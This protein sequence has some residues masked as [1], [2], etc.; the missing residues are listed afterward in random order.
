MSA[1]F[2]IKH[3]YLSAEKPSCIKNKVHYLFYA[4]ILKLHF[5]VVWVYAT[6]INEIIGHHCYGLLR[7]SSS[8]FFSVPLFC[9]VPCL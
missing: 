7:A 9:I 4:I 8:P 1:F 6:I 5:Q 3:I 2:Y